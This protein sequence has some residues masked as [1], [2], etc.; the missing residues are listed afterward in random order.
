[1]DSCSWVREQIDSCL[2]PRSETQTAPSRNWNQVAEYIFNDNYYAKRAFNIPSMYQRLFAWV[3]VNAFKNYVISLRTYAVNFLFFSG[4]KIVKKKKIIPIYIYIHIRPFPQRWRNWDMCCELGISKLT[5]HSI[6]LQRSQISSSRH[7]RLFFSHPHSM[8]NIIKCYLG[9]NQR[10]PSSQIC[11]G[12]YDFEVRFI[13]FFQSF[14]S[15]ILR[16]IT[17]YSERKDIFEKNT[18]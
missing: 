18:I 3:C 14:P 8:K 6:Y 13:Y 1:M 15:E 7:L 16:S 4:F 10:L 17:K 11:Q 2:F 5:F 12:I 9:K